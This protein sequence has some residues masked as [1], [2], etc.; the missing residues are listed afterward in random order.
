MGELVAW[1]VGWIPLLTRWAAAGGGWGLAVAM[2]V[3]LGVALATGVA[4]IRRRVLG[5]EKALEPY[6]KF[7]AAVLVG[8]NNYLCTTRLAQALRDDFAGH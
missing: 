4:P 3:W 7:K 1:V 8:K 2:A 5:A 6:A